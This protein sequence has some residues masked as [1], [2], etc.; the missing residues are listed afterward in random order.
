VSRKKGKAQLTKAHL[1]SYLSDLLRL[2]RGK[3]GEC[4]LGTQIV[5]TIL[6][7]MK[8]ALQNGETVKIRDFGKFWVHPGQRRVFKPGLTWGTNSPVWVEFPPKKSVRFTP[9][10]GIK[11]DTEL[12]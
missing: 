10:R 1:A 7:T 5:D 11:N 9:S 6:N 4:P 3:H 8:Q 12:T 2:P